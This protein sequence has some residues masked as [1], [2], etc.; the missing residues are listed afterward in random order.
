MDITILGSGTSIP[1]KKRSSPS[2]LVTI[3]NTKILMDT[4]PGSLRQ[5]MKTG[6]SLN[7]I[8]TLIYSHFHVDHIADLLPFIF[9]SKNNPYDPRTED[10]T[11]IGPFGLEKIYNSLIDIHG[12]SIVP[13]KFKINWF[14]AGSSSSFKFH[15]YTVNT[16][17]VD[18]SDNSIAI[19]ICDNLLRSIAYSGDTD[20]CNEI[21]DLAR[22]CD[23]L[24]LECSFP[25][26][27]KKKGHLIPS[28][29][30]SIAG[31][32]LPVKLILTHFYPQCDFSDMITPVKHLFKGD[33]T[34]AEDLLKISI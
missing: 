9:S 19:K 14:E 3:D 26:D 32:A 5:L 21:I 24:V 25:E 22:G 6:T 7:Q 2:I 8:S 13:D 16:C 15:N 28:E 20:Y 1:S 11:I 31:K 29:A 4:G 12:A 10:L 33:V 30:G 34:L 27:Q 18:H 17:N 23:L